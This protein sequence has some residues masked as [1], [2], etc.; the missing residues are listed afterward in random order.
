M[1]KL[2]ELYPDLKAIILD[3]DGVLWRDKEPIGDLAA[4]FPR[5]SELGLKVVLATNNGTKNVTEYQEKLSDFG[6]YLENWQIINSAMACGSYLQV[7]FPQGG[8]LYVVGSS[9]LKDTLQFY[10]FD[11]VEEG[12]PVLAVVAGLDREISY[13]KLRNATIQIYKG[14]LFIG[15]NPDRTFPTPEGLVPG[16]G[17]ILAALE[18]ATYIAPVIVGKPSPFLYDLAIERL[19]T[20]PHQTIAIGDR[21]DTDILGGKRAGLK[22]ALLLSGVEDDSKSSGWDPAPDIV[23]RDLTELLF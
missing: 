7:Q 14:A 8:K 6:V 22:T 16:A 20:T 12:E 3:M 5:I 10:G 17:S 21:Y 15:T 1:T 19:G 23:A 4:I 13:T 2:L 18:A 11:I 9:S